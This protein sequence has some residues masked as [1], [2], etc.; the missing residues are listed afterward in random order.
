MTKH[1][2]RTDDYERRSVKAI[3]APSLVTPDGDILAATED[4]IALAFAAQFENRLLFDHSRGRWY[5]W[6]WDHWQIEETDLAFDY[7]R[8]LARE[9]RKQSQDKSLSKVRFASEVERAARSDRRLVARH[10]D[11][12]C[13][14]LIFGV[15]GGAVDL[16]T[17]DLLPPDPRMMISRQAAVTPA[18]QGTPAPIWGAFLQEA[19]GRD[20]EL[21]R[22]L[23][24]WCGYSLTGSTFEHALC[25][26]Y[27]PGGNGKSVFINTLIGILGDYAATAAMDSFT[28]KRF[29]SHSTDIAALAGARLVVAS[30][31]EEGKAWAEARLKQLTG[32]DTITARFMRQD[33]F[34][35]RPKFKL[36]ITGNYQPTL[37]GA[38]PAMQ[39]R[40]NIVPFTR[41]PTNP[42]K[43]LEEKLQAEWPAILRWMIDGCL[44]WQEDG[45]FQPEAV[46]VATAEYFSDQDLFGQWL[47]E[48]CDVDQGNDYKHETSAA[49]YKSYSAFV[50]DHGELPL[51]SKAWGGHMRKHHFIAGNSRAKGGRFYVGILLL[52]SEAQYAD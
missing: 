23:Q 6:K 43:N 30:E 34:T 44:A 19:T 49:L 11:W 24:I 12:D 33:N 46:R 47:E 25:F 40:L 9:F 26:V 39:R 20:E 50:R 51:T 3:T 13:D 38:D 18:P 15:P 48:C 4:G 32:G 7:A 22:F 41:T 2:V 16:K 52:R 27:G 31:T 14:P 10:E 42:D 37:Q 28:A 45:L 35:F 36:T 17:G 1:I 5:V 21:I 8:T 29:E